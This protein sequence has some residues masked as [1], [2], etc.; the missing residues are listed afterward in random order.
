[1][2]PCNI[3][4]HVWFHVFKVLEVGETSQV[5]FNRFLNPLCKIWIRNPLL[6]ELSVPSVD[7]AFLVMHSANDTGRL[8]GL[9]TRACA[10]QCIQ[11]E[12]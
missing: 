9:I 7:N 12:V 8:H 6:L 10:S 2:Y 1:M 11:P 3:T 4:G 5:L